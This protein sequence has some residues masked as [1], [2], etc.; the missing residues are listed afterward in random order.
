MKSICFSFGSCPLIY[1]LS[2]D[3]RVICFKMSQMPEHQYLT[4]WKCIS[5]ST[6]GTFQMPELASLDFDQY[7]S[8]GCHG[9]RSSCHSS[10]P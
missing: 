3:V 10:A 7:F 4:I 1:N 5:T 9:T 6:D 2:R 8:D